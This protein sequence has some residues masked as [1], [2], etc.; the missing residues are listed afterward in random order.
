MPNKTISKAEFP[1]LLLRAAT[2]ELFISKLQTVYQA[3]EY[4]A[5]ELAKRSLEN[6]QAALSE[7]VVKLAA[8]D[9]HS[10]RLLNV[11]YFYACLADNILNSE[12]TES[13]VGEGQYFDLLEPPQGRFEQAM[14]VCRQMDAKLA[15]IEQTILSQAE[16]D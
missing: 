16:G 11:S 5:S 15:A 3:A 4:H 8:S 10:D 1:K 2:L 12:V 7:A 13:L 14:A 9:G 6:A